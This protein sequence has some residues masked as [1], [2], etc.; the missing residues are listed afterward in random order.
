MELPIRPGAG[1]E[2]TGT[3]EE[4]LRLFESQAYE[5]PHPQLDAHEGDPAARLRRL[6][7]RPELL[8][9]SEHLVVRGLR[10]EAAC[11]RA[12]GRRSS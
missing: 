10:L 1:P 9:T 2:S 11:L 4:Q 7:H 3:S 5:E 6:G 8:H 12:R